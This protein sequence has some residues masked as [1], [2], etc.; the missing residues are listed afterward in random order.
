MHRIGKMS[1][2]NYSIVVIN[3][4]FRSRFPPF[5][6]TN[7]TREGRL[8]LRS[9]KSSEKVIRIQDKGS[10]FV[11]LSQQEYQ[12]KMLGQLNNDLH[13]DSV[14][15]DP[16]LDHFEVVKEW[17]RK[18]FSEGQISQEIAVLTISYLLFTFT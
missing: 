1:T 6:K 11:V 14:D 15:S 16:T 13:Y 12:N 17:S 4:V 8:A 10:R 18:W 2:H 3:A 7:L 9:L 5:I